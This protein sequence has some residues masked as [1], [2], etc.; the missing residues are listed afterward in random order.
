MAL[1]LHPGSVRCFDW[2]HL[3][4]TY[5]RHV[6]PG[7]T[8]LEIGAST[9]ERTAKLASRCRE[10]I[11]IELMPE[12][13][14]APTE[15]SRFILG[16]W[17]RLSDSIPPE[18][19]DV[20]I[21]SHVIEHIPDDLHAINELY[22]VLKPGGVAIINTPNRKRLVR[23]IIETFGPE[24]KFPWWEHV[25]EYTEA[26]LNDL[27]ARSSFRRWNIEGLVIGLHGGPLFCYSEKVPH[28]A[29]GASNFWEIELFRD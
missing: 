18:S 16:N 14:P 15:T 6:V 26:D 7:A 23:S 20:A 28:F 9:P 25:R 19:V 10:L 27:L 3:V 12:R 29:R 2:D 17:E 4:E 22:T 11:G 1:R 5:E 8:V 21:A 13:L 24:R